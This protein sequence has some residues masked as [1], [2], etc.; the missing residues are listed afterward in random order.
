MP[1]RTFHAGRFSKTLRASEA[2][3]IRRGVPLRAFLLRPLWLPLL[4]LLLVTLTVAWSVVRNAHY[5]DLVRRSQGH[6]TLVSNIQNNIV[7]LETGQRGFIITLDPDF[8]QPYTAAR[9]D[10]PR[11]LATLRASLRDDPAEGAMRQLQRIE[12]VERLINEWDRRG[13]GVALRLVRTDYAAAVAQVRSGEGKRLVDRIRETILE[14]R[15]N[16][17]AQQ[18]RWAQE[19]TRA[20]RLALL[21]TVLGVL[22]AALMFFVVLQRTAS[23]VSRVLQS[24]AASTAGIAKG[25]MDSPL[26]PHAITEV[27]ALASNLSQMGQKL[28]QRERSGTPTLRN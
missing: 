7:D 17:F 27:A 16:E 28:F 5:E 1:Q 9:Q 24:L 10:L 26:P 15:R 6:Q 2:F 22:L 23:S 12:E 3:L 21:V 19:S 18:Q 11:H 14:F 13:G 25:E 4:L 8:L 20:L